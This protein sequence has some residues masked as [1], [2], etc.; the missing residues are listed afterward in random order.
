M[1]PSLDFVLGEMSPNLL[2]DYVKDSKNGKQR[3]M[4]NTE[5]QFQLMLSNS[6]AKQAFSRRHTD[7]SI[8]PSETSQEVW[9]AHSSQ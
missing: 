8:K 9:N 5:G 3:P 2:T 1:R 4:S 6:V 7:R